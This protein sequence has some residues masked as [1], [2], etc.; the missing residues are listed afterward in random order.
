MFEARKCPSSQLP[1]VALHAV[2]R[3][4]H[5]RVTLL[6]V[7]GAHG[8]GLLGELEG[9]Q[10]AEH[11]VHVPAHGEVVDGRVLNRALG[12]DE[13]EAA[14]GDVVVGERAMVVFDDTKEPDEKL[15][16][17]RHTVGWEG[18]L[19]I[20]SKAEP[21]P[22]AFEQSEPLRNECQAFLDAIDGVSHPP[23]D[24]AEGIR[25]LRVLEACQRSILQGA[26]IDLGAV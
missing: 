17:Y 26:S 11:L 24:A 10:G 12:I 3:G 16:L 20:V 6:P 18:E 19:A 15:L 8:A 14:V 23:S 7:G 2:E 9:V 25:V 21:E 22:I 4:G 1:D 13:E 5:A